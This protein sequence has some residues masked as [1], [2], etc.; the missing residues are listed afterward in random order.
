MDAFARMRSARVGRRALGLAAVTGVEC[1][2]LWIEGRLRDVPVARRDAYVR[3]WSRRLL[4][5]I[6]VRVIDDP[7]AASLSAVPATGRLVVSNHRSMLDILVVLSRF[8]GSMLSKNDLQRWPLVERLAAVADTLYVDRGS[9]A[10]GAASIRRVA[11]RL[12]RGRAVTVFAEGTTYPGDEVRPFH[13]GAFLAA[14]RTGAE[15]LPLGLAYREAE[16]IYWHESLGQHGRRLLEQPT[17]TVAWAVGVPISA[18]GQTTKRLAADAH[19]A[20]QAAVVGARAAL[21][22]H[23]L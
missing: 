10:S 1:G 6:G 20:V 22:K 9:G 13:A 18:A 2:A 15:V 21:A 14:I 3:A 17:I 12:A 4:D 8:G 16:A 23:R 11:D 19:A 7:A 5:V